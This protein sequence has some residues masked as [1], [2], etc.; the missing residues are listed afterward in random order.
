MLRMKNLL[1]AVLLIAVLKS[2]GTV[3]ADF[4]ADK[5]NGCPPLLANFTNTSTA[6]VGTLSYR[7]DFANGNASVTTT[8]PSA[9][10]STS[11]TYRVKLIATNGIESDTVTKSIVVFRLPV[12]NFNVNTTTVCLGDTL[13]LNSNITPGDAPINNYAWGFGN[14]IANPNNNTFYVYT[15]TGLYDIT[16]VVQDTNT[17]SVNLTRPQYINVVSGPQAAFTASPASSCN[18][19]ELVTFT[20]TSTGAGLSSFWELTDAVTTTVTNPTHTYS[21]Q[22]EQVVLTVTD[23]NGCSSSVNHRVAVTQPDAS[24]TADKT[25]VCTGQPVQFTNLGAFTPDYA[26]WTFGDGGTHSGTNPSYTY[27]TPGVYTVSLNVGIANCTDSET[28]VAYITVTQGFQVSFTM[29]DPPTGCDN[30]API[31]FTNTTP[32]GAQFQ[33]G[34]GDGSTGTGSNTSHT[35]NSNGTYTVTLT[36]TDSNGCKLP[37][38]ASVDISSQRPVPRFNAPTS[39]CPNSP[40]TFQNSTSGGGTYLWD[41]GD[42]ST[43]TLQNPVYSYAMPGTYTISLTV[44]GGN[45]CDST[46]IRP[47]YITIETVEADFSVDRTFSPCPPFVTVFSSTV[48]KPVSS[49]KWYFG[50]GKTDTAANPT[51]IYFHPGIYTVSLM[52]KTAN[53]CSDSVVYHDLI[54]VQGPSGQFSS[55]P[56][57][58]CAPLTVNFTAT[59][60]SNTKSIWCDLGDGTLITDSLTFSYTYNQIG[61]YNPK[62]ILVDHVGCTVPYDLPP[63]VTHTHPAIQ[64]FDTAVCEGATIAVTLTGTDRYRWSSSSDISCDTCNQVIITPTA[65]KDY[66]VTASNPYCAASDTMHVTV[67]PLPVLSSATYT[68]CKNSSVQLNAGSAVSAQWLPPMYLDDSSSTSPICTA[69]DS[70]VY[71]LT[72]ANSLGCVIQTQVSVNVID[73]LDVNTSGNIAACAMDSFILQSSLT[74]APSTPVNYVWYPASY[75]SVADSATATGYGLY[76]ETTFYVI[77][78]SGNCIA[79]TASVTVSVNSLPDIQISESV[80]TTPLAEVDMWASSTQTLNYQWQAADSFSCIACRQTDFYPTHTQ[81]VYVTGTNEFGCKAQDSVLIRVMACDPESIFLPNVF[82]PNGDGLNDELFMSSK[83][84]SSIKYFRVF[85]EWGHLIYETKNM[86]E[87]WDG[88]VNGNYAPID[89]FAYVL[90]GK[91][92]NGAP[93]LKYGNITLVR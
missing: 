20:N 49:Y 50:D 80:T 33:W 61:V 75:L 69:T 82:T 10:F 66:I 45:G 84:L 4:T 17:C 29:S 60:S 76:N 24:F 42:G 58:G 2:F 15:Q 27:T 9:I 92:S 55:D 47:N 32:G 52:V 23:S 44:F 16:L 74:N 28:K 22:E 38:T 89:V 34:F 67:D 81:T 40:I 57:T 70:I 87:T 37:G 26:N 83:V 68:V 48:N 93:V 62:F 86:N 1:L 77:A 78:S 54:E 59:T 21:Q 13:Y 35:Y 91:C 72:A 90:E 7:W 11:G 6:S 25:T 31:V 63:V 14:G 8:N 36:V 39:G 43:S 65:S 3:T 53:G 18:L 85:D 88:R 51:H 30:N 79:D 12:V 64:L 19:S 71:Q 73:R 5:F 41:F 46:I 56:D